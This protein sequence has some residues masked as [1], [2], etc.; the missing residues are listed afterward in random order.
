MR[1]WVCH[2]QLLLVLASTVILMSES[3]GTHDHILLSQIQDS[4]NLE[5]Q[6]PVFITPHKMVARLYPQALGS[7][8]V[9]SYDSQGYERG[10][11]PRLHTDWSWT[12]YLWLSTRLVSSLYNLSTDSSENT[13][14][15]NSSSIVGNLFVAAKTY[16]LTRYLEVD[17]FFW[18]FG[19]MSQYIQ[20]YLVN[21]HQYTKKWM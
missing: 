12:C 18:L 2:L 17:D 21:Y 14:S 19:V 5:G 9:T 4:S 3:C 15:K 8:F 11:W 16:L 20:L 1:G 13:A 6:V 10:I 7:L